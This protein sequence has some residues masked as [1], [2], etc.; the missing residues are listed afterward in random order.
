MRAFPL[1]LVVAS[2]TSACVSARGVAI[3]PAA[4][5]RPSNCSLSYARIDPHDALAKW[6]QVGSVCVTI[7]FSYS[8]TVDDVYAPG[9]AHDALT[10]EACDLGAEMVTPVSTCAGDR[11]RGVEFGAFVARAGQGAVEAIAVPPG[12]R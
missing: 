2:V 7:P 1:L 12:G 3:G 4:R 8:P 10:E 5:P 11:S 9:N 6:R